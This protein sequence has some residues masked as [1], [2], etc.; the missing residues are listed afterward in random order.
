MGYALQVGTLLLL[1]LTLSPTSRA[2]LWDDETLA[3]EAKGLPGL[4]SILT[5][6]YPRNPPLCDEMRLSRAAAQ[7]KAQPNNLAAHDVAGVACDRLGQGDEAIAWMEQKN[8]LLAAMVKSGARAPEDLRHH[9]YRCLANM[10][11]FWVHGW[12][13]AGGDRSRIDEVRTARDFINKAIALYPHLPYEREHYQL[14][15][16]ER[17]IAAPQYTP[18]RLPPLLDLDDPANRSAAAVQA[19][20]GLIVLGDEQNNLDLLNTLAQL[21]ERDDPRSSLALMARLRATR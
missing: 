12:A 17:I 6:R 10:G 15:M 9:F 16:L 8:L 21:L 14:K 20:A 19:L 7:I 1:T 4:G 11:T 5:G 13:R 18:G 2:S 3:V